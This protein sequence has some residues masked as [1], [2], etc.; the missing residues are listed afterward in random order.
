LAKDHAKLF[1][2]LRER[3][4]VWPFAR[5]VFNNLESGLASADL[6]VGQWYADMVTDVQLRDQISG[7]IRSEFEL[8][9]KGLRE[10]F[11][12]PL[13]ERRPRFRYTV[14][15]RVKPLRVL[16]QRQVELLQK[17]RKAEASVDSSAENI[18]GEV[19]Q[20]IAAIAA[21]LRTTG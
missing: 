11:S 3:L 6:E 18:L 13:A 2:R 4:R 14:E 8:V 9:Q 7:F 10:I 17:W 12:E 21:G 20:T 19:R 15:R 16:H 5:Y 1:R